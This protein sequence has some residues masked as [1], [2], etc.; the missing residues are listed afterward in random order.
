M[1]DAGCFNYVDKQLGNKTN[2]NCSID[3]IKDISNELK[4]LFLTS[5]AIQELIL[6]YTLVSN[7]IA[8]RY[9]QIINMIAY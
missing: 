4:D 3:I 1:T 9:V 2:Q 6:L 7:S 5:R 8:G